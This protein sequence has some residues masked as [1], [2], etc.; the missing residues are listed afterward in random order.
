MKAPAENI[1][2]VM[3]WKIQQRGSRAVEQLELLSDKN[4]TRFPL[5]KVSSV[6][7]HLRT[8]VKRKG[9]MVNML[10]PNFFETC[11]CHQ[12]QNFRTFY[13]LLSIKYG[14][15]RFANNW[16]L[17]LNFP[18]TQHPTFFFF[19][20]IGHVRRLWVLY[21]IAFWDTINAEFL[22]QDDY[23]VK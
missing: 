14:C 5:P 19:F 2:C 10:C 4:G 9:V 13:V 22:N 1:W 12:F 18:F 20:W 23:Q 8:V 15:M 17:F 21:C 3:K 11:C 6:P 7:R 16:S